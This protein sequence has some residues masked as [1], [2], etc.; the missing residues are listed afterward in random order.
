MPGS[1][2]PLI[3]TCSESAH[4]THWL[5]A[6]WP[7]F[8]AK[9]AWFVG[10]LNPAILQWIQE[11]WNE[12]IQG[13]HA[14]KLAKKPAKLDA[15]APCKRKL[16]YIS[17]QASMFSFC[18]FQGGVYPQM[19]LKNSPGIFGNLPS[20]FGGNKMVEFFAKNGQRVLKRV[21][22]RQTCCVLSPPR[23]LAKVFPRKTLHFKKKFPSNLD[24]KIQ[25]FLK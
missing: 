6:W 7:S 4:S 17:F 18:C 13:L 10:P 15:F 16:N 5:T 2:C 3:S 21:F 25:S 24:K 9:M 8:C 20:L 23:H 12:V 19:I 22:S 14:L 11:E 1:I